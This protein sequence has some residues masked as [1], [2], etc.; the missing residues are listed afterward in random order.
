[1]T[2]YVLA[3]DQGTT[4]T[5]AMIFDATGSV[6]AVAQLEHDQIFP[7]AGWVEHDPKQIWDNTR[8]VIGQALGKANVTRHDIAAVGITNQRETAVVWDRATGEPVC[9]AIVWQD[10]RTQ[11]IV[12]RIA[13]G[14]PDRFKDR[15]GLPLATYFSGTK[16]VWILEN[17]EGVRERAEAGELA[18][19]TMDS[20]V[21]WNLTGGVNGGV[22]ATDVTNASRT[23]FMDLATCTW[24]EEILAEFGVPLSMLPDIR[25]SSEVY[26]TVELQNLLRE[27]PVA[28]ILGDQQAATFGQAAF[29]AGE[30]KNTYGTG[31]FLIVN[32][33]DKIVHSRNGLLTTVAYR[34]GDDAPRYALEGSIAVTGSLVQWLRDNLGIISKASEIEE[35]AR[36]VDDNGGVYFVPAFSGLFA[37]HWRSDARGAILG[38]TRFANKGHIARAALEATAFQT[39]EVLD[40]VN[41]DADVTLTELKVDGGMVAN[42]ELMQFQADLLD[43]PVIRPVVAE[44]TALGAAYAAGLAVGFWKDLAE[45]RANWREDTRWEP[46]MAPEERERLLRNWKKAITKTLDWVDDDTV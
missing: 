34:L 25:S 12:D 43:I 15:V 44:T 22:H 4:S 23:L 42:A 29:D 28:G 37:P 6:V 36:S 9:N 35:L 19:G 32:T 45:L 5:R 14:N 8:E 46:T 7:R 20:W 38:L 41:A 30:S 21:L 31:N 13:A 11:P 33:G 10:T 17:V 24:N 27:V 18:F 3:I 16:I 1:M 2:K 39:R 40:A 26:G